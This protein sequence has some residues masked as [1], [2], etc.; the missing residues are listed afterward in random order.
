M[1]TAN[2]NTIARFLTAVANHS[3]DDVLIEFDDDSK[4]IR[5]PCVGVSEHGQDVGPAFRGKKRIRK[6]FEKLFDSFSNV[7]LIPLQ[8]SK[9]LFSHETS[10]T[11]PIEIGIQADLTG[12]YSKP[13]FQDGDSSRPLSRI[14][15]TATPA[16]LA[17]P[18][19]PADLP[20]I[21]TFALFIFNGAKI[22]RLALYLDRFKFVARLGEEQQSALPAFE[23]AGGARRSRVTIA[24]D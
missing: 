21:P 16:D 17:D 18:Q 11:G 19:F 4:P 9:P 15:P 8:N 22:S 6:L 20:G 5:T 13:W 1:P 14:K 2:E 24:I 23:V 10:G 12:Q 3:T 7:A